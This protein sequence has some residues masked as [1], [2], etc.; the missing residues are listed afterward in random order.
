MYYVNTKMSMWIYGIMGMLTS[1][2]VIAFARLSYGVILPFMKE[3]LQ[4]T[5]QEAGYLGTI[6]SLG[7]LTTLIFAGM[8]ATRWGGKKTIILGVSLVTIGFIGLSLSFSYW[9]VM[10][11]MLFLG[12]GTAFTYTPLISLLAGWFPQKRGVMIGLT[13]SGVGLGLLISGMVVPYF[14]SV[15]LGAGW[16][17]AWG[18][19]AVVSILVIILTICFI[20]DPPTFVNQENP[21]AKTSPKDIFRNPNVIKV[22]L[23]YGI[24]GL[25]YIVQIVFIMSFMVDSGLNSKIAGQLMAVNGMLAIFSGP[26]WGMLSDKLGRR[27]SLNISM[28][29]ALLAMMIPIFLPTMI[30]FTIHIFIFS[31]TINGLFTLVQ[32]SSMDYVK[33]EDVPITFSYVTLYFAVGQLI[34]PT[35]AGWLI[36]EWGGFKSAFIFCC[37]FL[38]IGVWI[39][40]KVKKAEEMQ[41][42]LTNIKAELN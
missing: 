23:L 10:M 21:Q 35:I 15:Y 8:L 11:F 5:Y 39:T 42:S 14:D 26:I 4:I 1:I 19:Y 20:K 38:I 16:R 41:E 9:I 36:D 12:I 7:Y 29:L 28:G 17:I 31:S 30:G 2:T 18:M 24:I 33:Q 34:G 25:T 27:L 22:G 40:F 6:T 37:V 13:A 32:A 3:G